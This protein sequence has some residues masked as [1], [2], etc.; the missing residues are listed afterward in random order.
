MI[1][2]LRIDI[3][4]PEALWQRVAQALRRAIVLGDLEPGVHLKEPALAQRFG[5]SRLPIREAIAQLE[6]EGL[7]RIE[8]RRGAFVVGVTE[9]EIKDIYDCRL[10]L[11]T[12]ALRRVAEGIDEQ[13]LA[14]LEALIDKMDA[15][16]ARGQ[17]QLVAVSDMAFHRLLIELS[18]NRALANAWEPL[19][20]LI[21]TVLSIAEATVQDLPEAVGGHRD[22]VCALRQHDADAAVALLSEHLPGGQRLVY[23]GITRA[24]ELHQYAA[25]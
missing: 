9:Q 17:V 25:I 3:A 23:E 7:V 5:V 13:G 12:Y 4:P 24:R 11:E 22:I 15:D 6:R 2:A 16:V 10:L 20:P 8:P 14:A 1:N 18:G 19:A 21:A